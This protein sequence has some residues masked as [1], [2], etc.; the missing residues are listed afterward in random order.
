MVMPE[1][2]YSGRIAT[3]IIKT[4]GYFGIFS[5]PLT[6]AEIHRFLPAGCSP[7]E[8]ETTLHSMALE[9]KVSCSSFGFYSLE[10][11][12]PWSVNRLA[13]NE[14]AFALLSR[15]HRFVKIIR[16]F[17]F[18]EAIAIS[19]SL[20]KYYAAA[21]ADI[22]Y[23]IITRSNRLWIS[24]TLLHL[25][26]KLTFIPGCQ[27][28][29]CM[30]YFVDTDAMEMADRNIY[31][32]IEMA[33]LIPVYNPGTIEGMKKLNSWTSDFLPNEPMNQDLAYVVPAGKERVKQF[34]EWMLNLLW[35]GNFNQFLMGLTDR[36]WRKKWKKKGFPM[37][38]YDR[39]FQT[40]LHVSKNHPADFQK[41]IM[42]ALGNDTQN[43]EP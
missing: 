3:G 39:A 31:T 11:N 37:N 35:P 24:R 15:S 32:A 19:G 33:T 17:P 29:F 25:F 16:S 42:L 27:H 43:P 38:D 36:K 7:E 2:G 21:D 34:T 22:D 28:Y 20:S 1:A 13:G 40:T 23:F 18:V 6:P 14:R 9:Q 41:R 12:E 10:P 8:M 26:K 5:Y 4:L 30:N